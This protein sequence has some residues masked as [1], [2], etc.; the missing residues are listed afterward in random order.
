MLAAVLST[1]LEQ[2]GRGL[3]QRADPHGVRRQYVLVVDRGL[4]ERGVL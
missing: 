4:L 1:D 3:A 2:R